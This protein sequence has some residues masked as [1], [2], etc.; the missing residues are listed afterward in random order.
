MEWI[1]DL[2]VILGLSALALI[3]AL[4]QAASTDS[5]SIKHII[6]G[7]IMSAFV[8][9][10]VWLAL[11]DIQMNETLRL[12]CAGVAGYSARYVLAAW[13]VIMNHLASDPIKVFSW[14]MKM[15]RRK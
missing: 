9:T 12:A 3:G 4:S 5:M 10:L 14:I 7:I 11:E 15:V 1:I 8:L 13:N 6:T 2:D